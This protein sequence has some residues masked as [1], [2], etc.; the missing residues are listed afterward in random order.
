MRRGNDKKRLEGGIAMKYATLY[1]T[2]T[3]RGVAAAVLAAM[4]MSGGAAQHA[5]A[6]TTDPEAGNGGLE[7]IVVTATRRETTLSNTPISLTAL[8]SVELERD[9]IVTMDDVARMVP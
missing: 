6:A 2:G 4:T 8:S 7:E 5:L 3:L 1:D 9:R